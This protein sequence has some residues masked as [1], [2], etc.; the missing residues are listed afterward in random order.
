MSVLSNTPT[1]SYIY[2]KDMIITY[3]G[4]SYIIQNTYTN[5]AYIYWD[6][7]NPYS[8]TFSNTILKE[9]AGRFYIYFNDK[10]NPTPVP[11]TELEIT[12]SENVSKD[13]INEK[14]L[15]IK[16]E[17][18]GITGEKFATIEQTVDEIKQ[19]VGKVQED[20]EGNTQ[21]ISTLKQTSDSIS[22]EV[23]SLDRKFNDDLEAKKLRDDI[24]S[25]IL[26]LQSTLGLFSSDMSKYMEDN[27]LSDVEKNEINSYKNE[28]ETDR[29][30]LNTYLDTIISSLRAN[31]QTD[32]VNTLTTQKDLLNASV[33]N[34]ITNID[35]ACT[36]NVF[37]NTE[38]STITS[39]FAN[40]NS[41]LTETKNLVSDYIFLGVGGDLI[42]EIGKISVKQDQISLSVS[43]TESSLKNS[44][45]LAK[46]LIQDIIDSNNTTLLNYKNCFNII[47]EDRTI[48]QEEIDSLQLR[49]N[50]MDE[51]VD[52]INAKKNELISN[53]LLDSNVKDELKKTYE[54]FINK[55]QVMKD[56]VDNAISNGVV[57]DVELIDINKEINEYYEQLN[58]IHSKMCDAIDNIDSNI[59]N[60]AIADAKSDIQKEIDEL[61]SIVN[62]IQVDAEGAILGSFI[63]RQEKDNILQNLNTLEREKIDVDNRF[64]EW[65]NSSFLYGSLKQT[66]KQ[67][68]DEYVN[69]YNTLRDLCNTIANKSDLVSD[70]ERLSIENAT[71]ELLVALDNFFK[72]SETVIGI[73]TS[74]E[75]NYIKGNLSKDFNDINNAL[76]GLN[77]QMNEAFKDGIITE[78]ELKDIN[79]MLVQ[80]DKEKMDID[81]AYG[82]IYNNEN[83]TK[84]LLSYYAPIVSALLV[85]FPNAGV[86]EYGRA[87]SVT[88][89]N[90]D[91]T[92]KSESIQNINFYQ[93]N[94]LISTI[95]TDCSEGG[96]F[97][98][99]FEQPVSITSNISNS[100][101]KVIV[102]DGTT[103]VTANTNPIEFVYPYYYGA[104]NDGVEIN[105]DLIK[106]LKKEVAKKG[107][108]TYSYSPNYQKIVIA[109]PKS[110]GVLKS[111]VDP[112]GFELKFSF[113]LTEL[114]IVGLDGK[115]QP[116]YVYSNEASTNTDFK[117]TFK[118]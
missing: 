93:N 6:Y 62:N 33:R 65:Y 98:Y 38:I 74:N 40:V 5:K 85:R 102:N 43:K 116:Y 88:K 2:I 76:N 56:T 34:L 96:T 83:L 78:M 9:L 101:F 89:I 103:S 23:S 51:T 26:A 66:Y 30:E 61:S 100:Y 14:I 80:L 47:V 49:I 39:Y 70:E 22:A 77:T 1:L 20:I 55:Y 8:L 111:I 105:E 7:N 42:E 109:Y 104:I 59:T 73:I 37:T 35:T 118:Y 50:A 99:T 81:K 19:T 67:V 46:S 15:G 31:G 110:Y 54:N 115:S 90:V 112:N 52:N 79:S 58:N 94:N 21:Q 28:L 16:E 48:T 4:Q 3:K 92:K 95:S 25:A 68:Y 18:N 87:V 41:K 97:S 106:N 113:T 44:L 29:L 117:I 27:R 107:N 108:K 86:Y 72:E 82:E 64:N 24:S 36:D 71:D 13:L 32:K 84:T 11:Q 60:K 91:V 114:N 12:F 57:N 75:M 63:D 45:N 69:K 10:G 17:I 53:T